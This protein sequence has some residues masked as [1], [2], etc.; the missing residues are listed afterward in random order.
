[1]HFH[2]TSHPQ[3]R[4]KILKSEEVLRSMDPDSKNVTCCGLLERYMAR[5]PA[6]ENVTLAEFA[7]DYEIERNKIAINQPHEE[8]NRDKDHKGNTS[9]TF[10]LNNGMGKVIK[11]SRS[12]IIR[13]CNFNRMK[14]S[15]E[16]FREQL[17]L[18]VPWR[19][20]KNK[21]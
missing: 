3:K 7:A 14:D 1:M 20:D 12:K 18:F 5:P 16:Y 4:V 17:M 11:R 19:D 9:K 10:E 8:E 6:I 13:F 15:L 2:N 21:K